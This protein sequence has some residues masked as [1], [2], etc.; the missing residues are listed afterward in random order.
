[1]ATQIENM[2]YCAMKGEN[3]LDPHDGWYNV[4][5]TGQKNTWDMDPETKHLLEN[6]KPRC[7]YS[8]FELN[9]ISPIS[10]F[11]ISCMDGGV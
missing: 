3:M 9:R 10:F 6:R 8:K 2:L 1:M 7:M 11:F 4:S 5:R